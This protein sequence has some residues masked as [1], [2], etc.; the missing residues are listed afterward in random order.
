MLPW[1]LQ[2][3][4]AIGVFTDVASGTLLF[5]VFLYRTRILREVLAQFEVDGGLSLRDAVNRLEVAAGKVKELAADDRA[6]LERAVRLLSKIEA[7]V[8]LGAASV[9]RSEEAQARVAENLAV[10]QQA[11]DLVAEDLRLAHERAVLT[12][13]NP[14]RASGDAADAAAMHAPGEG[15]EDS[16]PEETEAGGNDPGSG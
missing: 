1:W 8:H 16:D 12:E 11:V 6:A 7:E 14:D 5:V 9:L 15:H 4:V 13:A 3:A 10:A 2:L